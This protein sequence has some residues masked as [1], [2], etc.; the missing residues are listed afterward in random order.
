MV[1]GDYS[2]YIDG[3]MPRVPKLPSDVIVCSDIMTKI[4]HVGSQ[5]TCKAQ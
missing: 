3:I 5:M 1:I 2:Q 4:T